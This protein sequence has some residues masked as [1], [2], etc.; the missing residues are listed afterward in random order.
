MSHNGLIIFFRQEFLESEFD[1][2][3]NGGMFFKFSGISSL[4]KNFVFVVIFFYQRIRITFRDSLNIICDFIDWICVDLPSE[5]DLGFYFISL[6][7]R[8]IPH[9]VCHTRH[10]YMA[11]LHDSDSSSH[12]GSNFS[13]YSLIVP[14][15]YDNFP[16]N[17]HA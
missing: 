11:A 3:L 10:T 17:S 15:S 5:F 8:Y 2:S 14:E 6:C 16:L 4:Q 13:L 9:V 7:D 12:P 1:L